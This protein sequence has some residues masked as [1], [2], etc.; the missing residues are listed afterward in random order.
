[1]SDII[2]YHVSS[3]TPIL[4]D[5]D[6]LGKVFAACIQCQAF[7]VGY[8]ILERKDN[9]NLILIALAMTDNISQKDLFESLTNLTLVK[10]ETE[11]EMNVQ[12]DS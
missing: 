2:L 3:E 10:V 6:S 7:V 8:N 5:H 12:Q 1:M 9:T 4:M 11:G